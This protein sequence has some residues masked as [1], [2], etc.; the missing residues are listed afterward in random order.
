MIMTNGDEYVAAALQLVTDPHAWAQQVQWL[1]NVDDV[2]A[3]LT[4]SLPPHNHDQVLLH[5]LQ[6]HKHILRN[7]H[8]F[9][10]IQLNV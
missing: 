8:A 4:A 10:F 7:Q 2:G 6:H 3:R 5:L 1:S 9:P